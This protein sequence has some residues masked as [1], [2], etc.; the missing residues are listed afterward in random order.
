M[1]KTLIIYSK[2]ITNRLFYALD[3]VL[4]RLNG[5]SYQLTDN[6]DEFLS[7][8]AYKINY[9][10]FPSE[11]SVHI[12][13]NGLLFESAIKAIDP[14]YAKLHGLHCLFVTDPNNEVP[15]D[16]F[17]ATFYMLTRYEEY[18]PFTPDE[19]GRFSGVQS[20]AWKFG[21]LEQPVV[22]QW[23]LFLAKVLHARFKNITIKKQDFRIEAT[24]DVDV[25]YAFSH[26]NFGRMFLASG[27]DFATL[28]WTRLL[29]RVLVGSGSK[30][31][32]FD[33]YSYIEMIHQKFGF[34]VNFFYLIGDYSHFDRNLPYD[35]PQVQN[36]IKSL[37]RR[38]SIGVHPSYQA[39][40][41]FEILKKEV[42]R[43]SSITGSPVTRSRQ[44][45]LRL[46]FPKTYHWLLKVGITDDYSMGYHDKPG[47]RAGI[48]NPF[49]FYDLI[50]DSQ[51]SLT[52]H[53][54]AFMERTLKDRLFL[55]PDMALFKIQ[56]L[57]KHVKQVNGTFGTLWHND[58]LSNYGEW[59]R[60]RYVYEVMLSMAYTSG[61]K[62]KKVK[63][64]VI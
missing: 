51:T 3:I 59:K 25:A 42:N 28:Q 44:H 18:L 13:P 4:T 47:F 10:N 23:A 56:E 57:I 36:L 14:K 29:D 26:R 55:D 45:F 38:F 9:S 49:P 61:L 54:F 30:P 46:S 12:I 35:S 1:D 48:S 60:W 20:V 19:H 40:D 43:L 62:K 64:L 17:S 63:A 37:N 34:P 2:N 41:D 58:S 11:N 39:F 8:D 52:I 27:R 33:T 16:I 24:I 32:P 5:I 6:F 15:F 21:F 31:D 53:P 22:Q 50:K 7:T